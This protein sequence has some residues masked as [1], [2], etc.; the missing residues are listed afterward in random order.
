M[1]AESV[2]GMK[3]SGFGDD[4]GDKPRDQ[5]GRGHTFVKSGECPPCRENFANPWLKLVVAEDTSRES[6]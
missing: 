3:S 4:R 1:H 5:V 6:P 2:T